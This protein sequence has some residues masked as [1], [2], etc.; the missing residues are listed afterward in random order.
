[1]YLDSLF[2]VLLSCHTFRE[3][4]EFSRNCCSILHW[5]YIWR[6]YQNKILA[7]C[8]MCCS[9]IYVKSEI[10][11]EISLILVELTTNRSNSTRGVFISGGF[12][13]WHD[14]WIS[15]YTTDLYCVHTID[16]NWSSSG[17]ADVRRADNFL[18]IQ[19]SSKLE[20]HFWMKI[21]FLL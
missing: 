19:N 6:K 5:F 12:R 21:T 11:I 13:H 8:R 18:E 17:H 10:L 2:S 3:Y 15:H 20:G 14:K 9:I 4:T 1:M 16:T 7:S